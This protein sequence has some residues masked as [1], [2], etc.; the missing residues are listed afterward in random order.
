MR[1]TEYGPDFLT[2]LVIKQKADIS[3]RHS[4]PPSR[5]L[6][7]KIPLKWYFVNPLDFGP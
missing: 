5:E 1:V 7:N 2:G 3:L 4:R 6:P